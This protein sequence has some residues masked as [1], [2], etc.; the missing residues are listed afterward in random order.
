[1]ND[2]M[3]KTDFKFQKKLNIS[4]ACMMDVLKLIL[5]FKKKI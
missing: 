4:N 1:M 5:K 2:L 3:F